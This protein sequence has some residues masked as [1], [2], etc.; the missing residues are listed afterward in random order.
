VKLVIV[1]GVRPQFIKL[2]PLLEE[3][4]SRHTVKIVNTGQHYERSLSEDLFSDL[5]TSRPDV[6][7]DSHRGSRIVRL[8]K[9]MCD[10]EV[11]IGRTDS[12]DAVLVLGDS[13]PA[14]TGSLVAN[15]LG[16][17]L[18]HIEAGLRSGDLDQPEERNRI[19]IDAASFLCFAPS[20]NCANNLR[21]EGKR[22]VVMSGDLHL[23]ALQRTMR[24]EV[25]VDQGRHADPS[26]GGFVL[27]TTH[28]AATLASDFK[29]EAI[30]GALIKLDMDVVW[31]AH[32]SARKR[33]EKTGLMARVTADPRFTVLGPQS[34][35][36][37][38]RL[39]RGA[40]LVMTD[41]GGAQREA[42]FLRT[43]CL[44]LRSHTEFPETIGD[45]H[46]L[47]V[48]PGTGDL[49]SAAQELLHRPV[50]APDLEAFG[51]GHAAL[52]ISEGLEL[53]VQSS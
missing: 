46:G 4:R 23:D 10:L 15:V 22:N 53:L 48:E 8:S 17:P 14:Y 18:A 26:D 37:F 41:S 13:D 42:Y 29:L 51:S 32:P 24:E 12:P 3:L 34:H 19:V 39:L 43:R 5:R 30:V 36:E 47:L 20:P 44:V 2:A 7:L 21:R 6:L 9:A 52:R 11:E 50:G 45:G 49:Y 35:S 31:L 16:L 40:S 25:G 1:V 38:V 28:R 27:V 33:L